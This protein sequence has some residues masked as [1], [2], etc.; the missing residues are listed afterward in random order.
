MAQEIKI[1]VIDRD[2]SRFEIEDFYWFEE[3]G[4][5]DFSESG[6]Y[7]L[8]AFFE[9]FVDGIMVFSSQTI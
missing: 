3:E 7:R 6:F 1:F 4:V 9:I 8:Y 5:H 2:G